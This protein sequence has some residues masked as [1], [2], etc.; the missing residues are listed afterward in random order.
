MY[1]IIIQVIDIAL[2]FLKI[3][4]TD[5]ARI[6]DPM[7]IGK[8]YIFGEF[9]FD[10]V[11]VLPWSTIKRQWTFIRYLKYRKINVY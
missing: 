4:I 9:I 6:N 3:Q 2:N 11:A 7:V 8:D 5:L 1:I 10:V